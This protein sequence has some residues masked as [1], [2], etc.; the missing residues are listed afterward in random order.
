MHP[1]RGSTTVTETARPGSLTGRRPNMQRRRA[2]RRLAAAVLA[3]LFAAAGLTAVSTTAAPSA[4]A[5]SNALAG[6][7]PPGGPGAAPSA[8]PAILPRTKHQQRKTSIGLFTASPSTV[9][10]AG[11][12]VHLLAVVQ[13]ATSCQF[14]STSPLKE[15]P[16]TR[17]CATGSVSF[18]LKLPKNTAASA[19]T[20]HFQVAVHGP[21]GATKAG[22]VT[23]VQRAARHAG[24]APLLTAEPTNQSTTAGSSVSFTASSAGAATAQWQVSTDGGHSW[25]AIPGA[26]T[27]TYT[28]T[29]ASSENGDEYRAV[30]TR[31]GQSTTTSAA[32]LTVSAAPSG[33]GGSQPPSSGQSGTP[34]AGAADAD[35]VVTAQPLDQGVVAGSEV[36]FT[37]AASGTPTPTVQWQ[38]SSDGGATWT[39]INGAT[40][41]S[42]SFAAGIGQNGQEFRAVFTNVAATATTRAATLSVSLA[43]QMPAVTLNPASQSIVSGTSVSFTAAATGVPTPTVEWQVSTD[44]F[45]WNNAATSTS[46]SFTA[47][48]GEQVR[49]VFSNSAGTATT[50]AA[51]LT[52]TAAGAAP[53]ITE[54][55]F[56]ETVQSGTQASFTA[57]ASGVPAPSVQWEASTNGG[58]SWN[59]AAGS[60][61]TSPTYSFTTNLTESGY[62]YKA[63]FSNGGGTATTN[64]VTLTVNPVGPSITTQPTS[65]VAT[66]G[67]TVTFTAAA[68]G[69]PAPTVQWQV[70]DGSGWGDI[71]GAMSTSYSFTALSGENG[72]Q[73]RAVFTNGGGSATTNAASLTIGIAAKTSLNWSGYV[74]YG[75]TFSYVAGDWTVPTASCSSGDLY[76]SFWVGIDGYQSG[77]VEQDGTDS[78]CSLGHPT[79]YAWYEMYPAAS[80]EL[81]S[82]HPVSP[83]DTMSGSV[84]FDGSSTWTLTISDLSAGWNY[85]KTFSE[86]GLSQASAEW[87]AERP[88]VNGNIASLADFGSVTF[89]GA[90]ATGDG[91]T[92]PISSFTYSPFDM[93]N[94]SD[95][96]LAA[97]GSLN[98][99]GNGFAD[100]WYGSN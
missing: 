22:P 5:G 45:T 95:S 16:A 78:D 68:S 85:P 39:S 67:S 76:A 100:T 12:T 27:S 4:I 90:I 62:E 74:D 42:Y 37:V 69:D 31:S 86:T 51:T 38:F 2:L 48:I 24:A 80:V 59:N 60:S 29:A 41:T 92:G 82:G 32:T 75:A 65:Q 66:S 11:G 72:Y 46:Y 81:P 15:L 99:S 47:T 53:Q 91:V 3:G 10:A 71:A 18:D 79:Y 1:A 28:F 23:V 83:G 17:S 7:T 56:A 88:E 44:G 61:A 70:D 33:G 25:S 35:P 43:P 50:S 89:S 30:F 36:T 49:A 64:T 77:S 6:A 20:Y 52:V 19:R 14:S 58:A 40:S 8:G 26:T 97:P 54:Q 98:G 9:P 93:I 55:P 94:S 73:Y 21:A 96:V 34:A 57:A 87:V 84:S 13:R 63:V